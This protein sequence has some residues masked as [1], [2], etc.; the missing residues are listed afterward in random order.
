R[1]DLRD[2]GASHFAR[3][4]EAV[5]ATNP[6]CTVEVLTPDFKGVPD[7]LATVL[8]ARP[9]VFSHN[10]ETVPRLYRT[11]RPGSRYESSLGLLRAA[12]A[13]RDAHAASEARTA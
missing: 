9:E 10:I 12:A 1:D 7:A 6:G 4:I 13:A 5:R 11:A 8:A 3:V 2:G